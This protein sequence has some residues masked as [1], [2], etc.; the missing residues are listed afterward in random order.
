ML[1][2]EG[3]DVGYRWYN[4]KNLTPMFPFGY[5]LS[6]TT[7]AFSGLRISRASVTG[8]QSVRVS[9]TVTNTGH[10]AGTDVAQ[11]YLGDPAATGE[12]P[13]QLVGFQRVTLGAGPVN[14][15][16]V[17]HHA[18]AACPGGATPR[19]AGRRAAAYTASTSATPRRWRTCRCGTRS[20]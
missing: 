16:V 3:V 11:L 9:A 10:G 2:S 12:P 7:F 5:G 20:I 15:R 4:A 1:Y 17:H 6:Y 13:R 18:A 8:T 14:A 19:T